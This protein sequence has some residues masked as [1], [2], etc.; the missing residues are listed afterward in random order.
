MTIM[1]R[2]VSTSKAIRGVVGFLGLVLLGCGGPDSSVGPPPPP[3]FIPPHLIIDVRYLSTFTAA[4]KFTIGAAADRWTHALVT[5]LGNFQLSSASNDCF[6]GEPAVH[7]VHHDVLLFLSLEAVDGPHGTL[8]YT[9]VCGESPRD[10]PIV[11]HIRIDAA[12]MDS[13]EA[14]GLLSP[15]VMHR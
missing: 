4:Q 5:D 1:L 14:E 15:V 10:L 11:S 9:Q 8:A 7:E 12:D 13:L 3:P 2:A 6:I